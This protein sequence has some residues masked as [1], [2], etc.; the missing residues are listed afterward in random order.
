M[1][2]TLFT[3]G[4]THNHT[5]VE[6]KIAVLHH[7]LLGWIKLKGE[8]VTTCRTKQRFGDVGVMGWGCTYVAVWGLVKI[9]CRSFSPLCSVSTARLSAALILLQLRGEEEFREEQGGATHSH[10]ACYMS[11]FPNRLLIDINSK[12]SQFMYTERQAH[13]QTKG[14]NQW[15]S[16]KYFKK[17]Y[18]VACRWWWSGK[19]PQR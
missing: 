13:T 9:G 16:G 1:E 12:H 11:P 5:N 19:Q 8:S 18:N 14:P 6:T 3:S 15:Y 2:E 10:P 7:N 4:W 17:V